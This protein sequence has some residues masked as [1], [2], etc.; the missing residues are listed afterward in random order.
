M[1]DD[2]DDP[3]WNATASG[4][5]DL[6]RLRALLAPYGVAGRG[7]GEWR[8]RAIVRPRRRRGVAAVLAAGLAASLVLYG[9]NAWR[10]AWID[11][12]PWR[13][14]ASAGVEAPA[15]LV[16]GAVLE[17]GA[18][19]SLSVEV[20][21]IGRIRLSPRSTLRLLET[22]SGRHRVALDQGHLRA[23]IWAPP[24]YFGVDAGT[25]E[26]VD[27]GCDFDLWKDAAGHG[28]VYVHS[29]WIAYRV[30]A[31]EV[32]L[33]SGFAMDFDAER[34][35]TPLR[36]EA[37]PAFVQAVREL[38]HALDSA[39]G[40]SATAELSAERVATEAT[41]ADA[42]TLLSLLTQSPSLANGT[43]YPRLARALGIVADDSAHRAA[44]AAGDQAAI[45]AWWRRMPTQP[46]QWWSN[47]AD[48]LP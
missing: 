34:A 26:V 43:L 20:A 24:G 25:A 8:P 10:L 35:S 38:E 27:L 40:S 19:E 36:P 32:L 4:D 28:R 6:C 12:K 47:W 16:P 48:A 33:P 15:E 9:G 14:D 11:G 39:D 17:T 31:R 30:G 29:G 41:D 3:L 13:V 44:W 5:A 45:A 23:R 22:R 37:T 7:V 18:R 46:K 2:I 1:N 21:R 42:F